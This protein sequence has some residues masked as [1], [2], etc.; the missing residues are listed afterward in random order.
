MS[1]LLWKLPCST[2][3]TLRRKPAKPCPLVHARLA[4]NEGMEQTMVTTTIMGYIGT[5]IR[6][7][8]SLNPK[9]IMGYYKDPFLPASPKVSGRGSKKPRLRTKQSPSFNKYHG[10]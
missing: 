3:V 1:P 2:I 4:G 7:H 5:T 10:V 8:F 6:I 9:P